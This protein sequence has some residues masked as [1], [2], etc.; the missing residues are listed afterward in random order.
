MYARAKKEQILNITIYVGDVGEYVAK[1]ALLQCDKALHISLLN[2][3]NLTS[4][5]TYYT[6]VGDLGELSNFG[7]VLQQADTVVYAPP[8]RWSDEHSNVSKMQ[9]WTEQY[10]SI[11]CCNLAKTV[12]NFDVCSPSNKTKMLTLADDRKSD[13]CQIWVAGCSIS[14]GVGVAD[15]ERYGEL[16]AKELNLPATFLTCGGA[17][18][19]WASD[20][21]L[22][23]DIRANDVIFWGITGI[24]RLSYWDESADCTRYL[25]NSS[26]LSDHKFLKSII[27]KR[28]L[29]SDHMIY[30]SLVSIH[31]VINFCKI[32]NITLVLATILTGMECYLRG[33]ANFVPLAGIFGQNTDSIFPDI[34]TDGRHPGPKS[35][36]FYKEEMLKLYYQITEITNE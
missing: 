11:F 15:H 9:Y 2:F 28:Y 33:A 36:V 3:Q 8:I 7:Q 30:E 35:H 4:N 13:N 16:I 21:I 12:I 34:G 19:R 31:N 17:S 23:S 14:H 6:S 10:L 27:N 22:R 20:Q 29:A 26:L 25:T 5:S 24:G 18:T 32:N 1:Q